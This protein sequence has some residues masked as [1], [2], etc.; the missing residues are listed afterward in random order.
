MDFPLIY[1]DPDNGVAS[2]G[3][4]PVARPL[5]GLSKLV[6]VVVLGILKNGGQDVLTPSEGSGIRALLGQYN[7]TESSEIKIEI[8]QR[9]RKVESQIIVNQESVALPSD[10]KLREIKVL[11]IVSDPTTG[12][13]AVRL[14][15][16][17]EAGQSTTVVV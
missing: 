11:N 5:R 1:F 8:L 6:Q 10:E 15:V 16:I 7:Y 12:S 3:I 13:T 14:Q 2:I 4:P 9:L 17:N